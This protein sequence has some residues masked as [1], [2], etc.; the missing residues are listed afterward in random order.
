MTKR[1]E[2]YNVGDLVEFRYGRLG[3]SVTRVGIV[4][5]QSINYTKDNLY[6]IKVKEKDYWIRS[7]HIT[8]LSKASKVASK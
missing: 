3:A 5:E 1:I 7:S 2:P 8:L 6:K 4:V